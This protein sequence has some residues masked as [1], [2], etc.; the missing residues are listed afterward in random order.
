MTHRGRRV[1]TGVV[2]SDNLELLLKVDRI[3]EVTTTEVAEGKIVRKSHLRA[4]LTNPPA[5][6]AR[7]NYILLDLPVGSP[8][9]VGQLFELKPAAS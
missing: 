7:S 9:T 8:I 3:E 4:S 2:R 1:L 6:G 5:P